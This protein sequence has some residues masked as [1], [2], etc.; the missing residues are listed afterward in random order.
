MTARN[1]TFGIT[2]DCDDVLALLQA[3]ALKSPQV[4]A[5]PL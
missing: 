5:A 2:A 1:K 3:V 4:L